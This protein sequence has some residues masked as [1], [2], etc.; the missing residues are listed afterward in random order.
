MKLFQQSTFNSTYMKVWGCICN[1]IWEKGECHPAFCCWIIAQSRTWYA[2][3]KRRSEPTWQV[4]WTNV[5][6]ISR[7][8]GFPSPND[9]NLLLA[10]SLD[11]TDPDASQTTTVQWREPPA[12]R[13]IGKGLD[14]RNFVGIK[15]KY[16]KKDSW[17][18]LW[19]DTRRHIC[20]LRTEVFHFSIGERN[21][22]L[23]LRWV[24]WNSSL[25]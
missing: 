10:H 22:I 7:T 17:H 14:M 2:R 3:N 13:C 9:S 5:S 12:F 15:E 4:I 19:E 21:K 16:Q 20:I 25:S 8:G 18:D 1:K 11:P 6:S 23:K 24:S